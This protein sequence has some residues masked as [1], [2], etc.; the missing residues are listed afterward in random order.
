MMSPL[1]LFELKSS[2]G[3]SE[4]RFSA[5]SNHKFTASPS[6]QSTPFELNKSQVIERNYFFNL[7]LP[8]TPPKPNKVPISS[9]LGSGTSPPLG[10]W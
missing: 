7:R 1:L 3:I 2:A 10:L 5:C 4:P 8:R 6:A 9:V